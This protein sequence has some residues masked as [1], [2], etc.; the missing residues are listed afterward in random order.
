MK[1]RK[2]CPKCGRPVLK[3]K[4]RKGY[5]QYDF[6]CFGCDED[7]WSFEVYGTK[8]IEIVRQIQKATIIREGINHI[9][10]VYK[11]YPRFNYGK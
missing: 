8:D 3:S 2:F 10:S 9:H 6:Q 4:L 5:N 7:F 1:T 11:P